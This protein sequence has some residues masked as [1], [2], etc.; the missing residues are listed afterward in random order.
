MIETIQARLAAV[1]APGPK[2]QVLF[3]AILGAISDGDWKPGVRLPTEAELEQ[4][5][6]YSLGT[7]QKAYG[8][9]VKNGLVVRSRGRG[10]FVA[11]VRRQMSDPWYC[12][13]LGDDGSILPVYP[14]LIG[15]GV[16]AKDARLTGL[17]GK[18][19]KVVR[20][21]R[22]NSINDEFEVFSRFFSSHAIAKPLIRLPREKIQTANFKLILLRDLGLSITRVTQT[23]AMP[24]SRKWRKL[25]L[26]ARPHLVLESTAY[27]AGGAVA[28]FQEIYIPPNRRKLVFD[29]ELKFSSP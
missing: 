21:D 27:T 20:I 15:H 6:P 26:R 5:L 18:S 2:Y 1:E 25:P 16:A 23:I 4:K 13:F 9:L 7:I 24:D 22:A 28:F 12:R 8:E 3:N 29:S 10:S 19:V 17:F 11:P 14:R